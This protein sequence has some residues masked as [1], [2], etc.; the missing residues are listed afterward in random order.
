MNALED[1]RPAAAT[2]TSSNNP[3]VIGEDLAQLLLEHPDLE[4]ASIRLIPNDDGT[5]G[6]VGRIGP[7]V[8]TRP[9]VGLHGGRCPSCFRFEQHTPECIW[10]INPVEC[11]QCHQPTGRPHTDFCTLTPG[12]VWD[13]ALS[14]FKHTAAAYGYGGSQVEP[15][16]RSTEDMVGSEGDPRGWRNAVDPNKP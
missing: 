14:D 6:I 12:Q 15:G 7:L 13:G 11:P 8:T 2:T 1:R 10:G 16:Q 3:N 5:V 9:V 4:L